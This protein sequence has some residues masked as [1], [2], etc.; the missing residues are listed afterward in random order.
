V[1]VTDETAISQA[2]QRDRELAEGRCRGPLHGVPYGLK[3]VFDTAGIR[4]TWGSSLYADRVPDSDAAIVTMLRDAGAVLLGKLATAELANGYEWFEG[5]CTNPWNTEE[6]A[7]GSSSGSGSATAMALC[8]FSIGTDSLG[9]ILNPADRCG[10]VG[11]RPTFGRVPVK[12]GMPLTPSLE[13]IGP[14]CRSVEDAALVLA[15][16]NGPD[17]TS[18][19]SIDMGFEYRARG[20]LRGLKIGY[21]PGWFERIG[22][23]DGGGV[24]VSAAHRTALTSLRSL[25]AEVIEVTWPRL[26]YES[27]FALLEVESAAVFEEL[28]LDGSDDRLVKQ[29]PFAWPNIWRKAR[30]MSAVDYLQIERF[31][32][33]LMYAMDAL[34]EQV[35]ALVAPT[36][37][38]YQLLWAM[39]FTGHPGL[40]L[41]VGFD[42]SPT[43]AMNFTVENPA[44]PKRKVPQNVTLHG[45]LFEE[46]KLL[47]IGR[48]LE[49][50]SSAWRDRPPGCDL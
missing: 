15:A 9:S 46:G 42:E 31:R 43:R 2:R 13:R 16:I 5:A 44:G 1:T 45:R 26:P 47:A 48:L 29:G 49:K 40:T 22:Y 12:G 8:A 33:Q 37:G 7:G 20:D 24:S 3:D 10:V 23:G 17:P 50:A 41:R 32:R 35:D 14:L 18:A 25:G 21:S 38:S 28:T 30:M 11:L 19:T 39:N 6:P 27:L 36:Y 4:T 34:Y